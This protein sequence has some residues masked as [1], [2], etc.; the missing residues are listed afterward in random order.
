[1]IAHVHSVVVALARYVTKFVDSIQS[2]QTLKGK[3][4]EG[5][6]ERIGEW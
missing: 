5:G 6:R 2:Y 4:D 1:M 3:V